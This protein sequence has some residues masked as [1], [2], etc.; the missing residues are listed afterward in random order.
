MD[1]FRSA[2][3]SVRTAAYLRWPGI[4]L[5]LVGASLLAPHSANAQFND[6]FDRPDAA[7]IGN[8]WIEKNA[9]AF[10][11]ADNA[12]VKQPV[13]TGYRD[14]VVYRPASEDLLDVEA[15]VEFRLTGAGTGYPQV[16]TRIQ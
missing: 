8:G 12:A 15:S 10:G 5:T 6:T 1:L 7:A 4:F 2:R 3:A 9:Q 14:N 11:L 13:G 16:Y